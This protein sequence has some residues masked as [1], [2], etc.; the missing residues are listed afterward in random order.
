MLRF[1]SDPIEQI[2]D[3]DYCGH[4]ETWG[5]DG[6]C[7]ARL[8]ALDAYFEAEAMTPHEEAL[9]YQMAAEERAYDAYLASLTDEEIDA[10][11]AA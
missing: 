7:D 3:T 11:M 1:S 9:A 8:D 2:D 4:C 6:Q 5:C 10:R